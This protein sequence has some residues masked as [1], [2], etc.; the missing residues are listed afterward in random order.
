MQGS[1]PSACE[2][3]VFRFLLRVSGMKPRIK[4]CKD[5]AFLPHRGVRH[6]RAENTAVFR[7]DLKKSYRALREIFLDLHG[8]L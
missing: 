8:R 6:A 1:Y 5:T 3:D 7:P 4:L 2:Y